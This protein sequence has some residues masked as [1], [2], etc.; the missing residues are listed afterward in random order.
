MYHLLS[1]SS[2]E[3]GECC[4]DLQS[5]CVHSN[6]PYFMLLNTSCVMSQGL[7]YVQVRKTQPLSAGRCLHPYGGWTGRTHERRDAVYGSWCGR[8]EKE[9]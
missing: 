6:L 2:G 1:V 4:N 9:R 8:R 5:W 3:E 7:R